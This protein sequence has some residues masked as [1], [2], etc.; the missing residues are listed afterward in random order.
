MRFMQPKICVIG[1][2]Y[3]GLPTAVIFALHGAHV[4][5]VDI[6]AHAVEL[7]NQGKPHIVEPDLEAA[8]TQAVR[9]GNLKAFNKPQSADVFIITVPTPFTDNHQPD[10]SY[11]ETAFRSIIPVLKKGDLIILESTSP[12]GTTQQMAE[13]LAEER[14]DLTFPLDDSAAVDVQICYCPERVLPGKI[15]QE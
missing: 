4:F 15:L 7:I 5:G 3:I 11:V 12:V 14:S 1:L 6:N 13:L 9:S 8:L 10:I 2:G